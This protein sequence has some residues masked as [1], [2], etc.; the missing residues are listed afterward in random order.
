MAW[1]KR[2]GMRV[3]SLLASS[4]NGDSEEGF[5]GYEVAVPA[6]SGDYGVGSVARYGAAAKQF[7]CVDVCDVDLDGRLVDCLE[8]VAE[9]VAVVRQ[10]T[11]VNDDAAGC[12]A[13][14]LEKSTIAPSW[15]DW[16]QRTST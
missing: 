1:R 4:R 12:R 13:L 16:K 15:L 3:Q 9:G 8:G 10:G 6:E 14:L 7:A 11:R 2:R 5:E